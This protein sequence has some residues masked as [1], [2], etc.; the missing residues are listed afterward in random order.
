VAGPLLLIG[1][2]LVQAALSGS[3]SAARCRHATGAS[4]TA[5]FQPA[6]LAGAFAAKD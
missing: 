3:Y 1:L 5:G 2:A 6:L 4:A